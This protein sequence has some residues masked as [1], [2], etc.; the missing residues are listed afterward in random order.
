MRTFFFQGLQKAVKAG[1]PGVTRPT[2]S[3]AACPGE[4]PYLGLGVGIGFGISHANLHVHHL[5]ERGVGIGGASH[6]GQVMRNEQA[7]VQHAFM[8]QRGTQG[9][10]VGFGDGKAAV[11]HVGFQ[12]TGVFFIHAF[13]VVQHHDAVGVGVGQGVGPGAPP[14]LHVAENQRVNRAL[15]GGVQRSQITGCPRATPHSG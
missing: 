15:R 12:R 2:R 14:A 10:C 9:A 3:E 5:P 6:F 8:H 1:R 4:F 13:A 11:G 7:V